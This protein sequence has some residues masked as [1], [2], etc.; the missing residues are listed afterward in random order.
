MTRNRHDA[1]RMTGNRHDGL[2]K[3]YFIIYKHL[4][5]YHTFNN[6]N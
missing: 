6:K 1:N 3:S 2:K 5:F 4:I